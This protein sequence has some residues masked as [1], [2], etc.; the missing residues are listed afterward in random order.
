M[1]KLKINKLNYYFLNGRNVRREK[2]MEG[3]DKISILK[4][5]S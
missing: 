3:K 4:K 2:K 1:V 5:D